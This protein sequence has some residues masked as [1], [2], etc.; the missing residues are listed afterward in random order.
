MT[1]ELQ[2]SS[3]FRVTVEPL[4]FLLFFGRTLS[5][6]V[7]TNLF[8]KQTCLVTLQMNRS[9]CD[10]LTTGN[11]TLEDLVQPSVTVIQMLVSVIEALSPAVISMFLGPWSDTNGR[12]LLLIAPV[13]G[14][15][16]KYLMF[17]GFTFIPNLHPAYFLLCCIPVAVSGGFICLISACYS[18]ITDITLPDERAQRLGCLEI[19]MFLGLLGGNLSTAHLYSSAGSLGYVAVFATSG[20][21]YCVSFVY[22]L[23]LPESL[24][25]VETAKRGIHWSLIKELFNASF[26]KQPGSGRI[27][28][29]LIIIVLSAYIIIIEGDFSVLFL[30]T[31]VK[32]NWTIYEYSMFS[33]YGLLLSTVGMLVGLWLLSRLLQIP[34]ALLAMLGFLSK[35]MSSLIFAFAPSPWYLYLAIGVGVIGG[36]SGPLCRAILSTTVPSNEIGKVFSIISSLESLTP[37]V[38]SPL[39]T[40][41]YNKTL[42]TFPGACFILSAGLFFIDS[43]ILGVVYTIQRFF[44]AEPQYTALIELPGTYPVASLNI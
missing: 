34:S 8:L 11:K 41:V 31:K 3:K 35:M 26:L 13:L 25:R 18:Y 33:S 1:D 21:I 30:Y 28:V 43:L 39:Y 23:Y 29:F 22:A 15:I 2:H 10:L 12:K 19:A 9:T 36:I 20:I 32:Y 5:A 27:I 37:L 16:F 44:S 6:P 17:I 7:F 4:I 40:L 38:A 42:H 24:Q 14:F